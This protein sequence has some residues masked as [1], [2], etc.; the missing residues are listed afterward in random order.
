VAHSPHTCSK[1]PLQR[2]QQ[3]PRGLLGAARGPVA[4]RAGSHLG[5]QWHP[6]MLHQVH[7]QG[8]LALAQALQ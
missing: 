8:S 5:H 2:Q 7:I 6:G 4:G 3:R 1:H